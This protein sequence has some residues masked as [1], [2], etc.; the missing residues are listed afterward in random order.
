MFF[1][2]FDLINEPVF[3]PLFT[4]ITDPMQALFI[5]AMHGNFTAQKAYLEINDPAHYDPKSKEYKERM[6]KEEEAR[7]FII[8][9]EFICKDNTY[10][11]F[12]WIDIDKINDIIIFPEST[13]NMILKENDIV[14]HIIE[15]A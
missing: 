10:Q 15:K 9:N 12:Y 14:L 4:E 5:M 3:N 7:P 2:I 6:R 8:D 11:K 13:K 1:T